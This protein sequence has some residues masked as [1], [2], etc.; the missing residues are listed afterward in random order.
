MNSIS[1][2]EHKLIN[3]KISK[4]NSKP[5]THNKEL[6]ETLDKLIAELK[7]IIENLENK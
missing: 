6:I 2:L 1:L 4:S 5:K 3:T 7:P